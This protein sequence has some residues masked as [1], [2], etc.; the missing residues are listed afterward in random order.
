VSMTFHMGAQVPLFL[1]S[2]GRAILMALPQTEQEALLDD[3]LRD[4]PPDQRDRLT[5]GLERARADFAAHGYCTSFGEWRSEINGIAAPVIPLQGGRIH[6]VNVG[7]FAFL[8]PR[9]RLEAEY[10]PRLLRA[11]HNLSLRPMNDD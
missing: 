9:D 10:A 5:A 1:S 7:G 4:A 3:A 8:N 2:I 11:A 6:A